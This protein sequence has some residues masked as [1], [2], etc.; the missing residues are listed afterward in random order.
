M[1]R[2]YTIWGIIDKPGPVQ[3][4]SY[5]MAFRM[6]SY[7][8]SEFGSVLAPF[9]EVFGD[10]FGLPWGSFGGGWGALGAKEA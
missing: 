6:Q 1:T 10:P 4:L 5:R 9:W 2:L 3:L 8:S 7:T